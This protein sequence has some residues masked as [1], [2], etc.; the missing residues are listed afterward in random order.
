MSSYRNRVDSAP[1]SRKNLIVY[2]TFSSAA[3]IKLTGGAYIW[4]GGGCREWLFEYISI[5]AYIALSKEEIL[6][7]EIYLFSMTFHGSQ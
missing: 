3:V 4:W 7:N 6:E 5:P 2:K 1:E